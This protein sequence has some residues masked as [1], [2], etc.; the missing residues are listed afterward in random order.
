[1][2][3]SAPHSHLP[4]SER[5]GL[6]FYSDNTIG[7]YNVVETGTAL[8]LECLEAYKIPDTTKPFVIADLGTAD[9]GTSMPLMAKMVKT[10][11][12]K[13]GKDLPISLWYED[14][15]VNDFK[16]LF[17]RLQGLIPGPP[18]FTDENVFVYANGTSFFEQCFPA[19]SVDLAVSFTAMHWL[20]GKPGNLNDKIH[21]T[22]SEDSESK[23]AFAK[24]S[25]E[26]WKQILSKRG[27]E[28]AP[29][30]RALIV[31]FAFED[32]QCLGQTKREG[33][34]TASMYTT[35]NDIWKGMADEGLITQEEFT[36]TSI[37]NYYRTIEEHLAPFT[38][39]VSEE[40]KLKVVSIETKVTACPYHASWM[41]PDHG[42]R[43][44]EEHSKWFVPTTR[45]W[46]NT[47]Y[48]NGLNDSRTEDEKNKIVDTL[49]DRYAAEVAKDPSKHGMDYFHAY[50]VVEKI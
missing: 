24:L 2:A 5:F 18:V 12:E 21:H 47:S 31:N 1:M 42:G 20:N 25:G 10:L 15:P 22:I 41:T 9:G 44:A 48:M 28:L 17:M 8:A 3:T 39:G 4:L 35:K 37:L 6:G 14:Q 40:M 27:K 36:N 50:L 46:S 7:C 34:P 29:G 38:N 19:N 49:F 30:A 11:R 33:G 45:T 23:A 16:S 32:N 13:H 43:T 26:N